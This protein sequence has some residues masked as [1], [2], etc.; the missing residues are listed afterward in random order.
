MISI[1]LLVLMMK[2]QYFWFQL[3]SVCDAKTGY[4]TTSLIDC[5]EKYEHT[6]KGVTF[7]AVM[8]LMKKARLLGQG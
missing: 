6:N 1:Q 7:G 5:F 3:F 2:I 4:V 8:E